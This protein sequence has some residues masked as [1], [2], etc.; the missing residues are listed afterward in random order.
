MNLKNIQEKLGLKSRSK[1]YKVGIALGGGG[2][3][4]FVHLGV[5][6]ALNE[7]GIIPEIIAGTSAGSLAGIFIADGKSPEET[8]ELLK[9]KD[10]FGYSKIPWSTDGLLN[11]DGLKTLLEN[12][13]SAERIEDLQIPLIVTVTNLNRGAVMYLAEGPLIESVIAS[14]SVPFIFTP[15]EMNGHKYADGGIVDNLP[16]KP[17]V[18]QCDIIIA[19]S[20]SPIEETD[21]LDSILKIS[22]RTFQLSINAQTKEIEKNCS[23]FI[24]PDGIRGFQL[25]DTSNADELF[26]I[27]YEYV[28]KMDN[29]LAES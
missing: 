21:D 6:K 5:L 2:A 26:E 15:I 19:S 13:I 12:E 28:R 14:A 1:T 4:G 20:I 11:L 29:K 27:G 23:I 10:L 25:F 18:D 16:I 24:E 17:L 3:R 7:Q 22:G 8:H 9:E